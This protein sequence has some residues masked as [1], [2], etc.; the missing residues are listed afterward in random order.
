MKKIKKGRKLKNS[1]MKG[2]GNVK[3]KGR[4]LKRR[5]TEEMKKERW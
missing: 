2:G 1:N 5:D 3:W 4:R